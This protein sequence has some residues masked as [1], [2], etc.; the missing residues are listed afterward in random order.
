MSGKKHIGIVAT[1]MLASLTFGCTFAEQ[2]V[3]SYIR[4]DGRQSIKFDRVNNSF[5]ILDKDSQNSDFGGLIKKCNVDSIRCLNLS[6]YFLS[7]PPK[8]RKTDTWSAGGARFTVVGRADR[9][10][11]PVSIVQVSVNGDAYM[12]YNFSE[13]RGVESISFQQ[14]GA[15][16]DLAKTYFLI[17]DQG[18]L[19]EAGGSH[20]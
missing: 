7:A 10:N 15:T 8:S 11:D 13:K 4:Q 3:I 6:G 19:S 16:P 17:G 5:V 12:F 9:N 20:P 2:S 18:L 14:E 1:L